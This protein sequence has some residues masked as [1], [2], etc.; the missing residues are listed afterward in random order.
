MISF[1]LIYKMEIIKVFISWVE[2]GIICKPLSTTPNKAHNY[3]VQ[4]ILFLII[5]IYLN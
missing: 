1:L 4:Y 3:N 5:F 2:E